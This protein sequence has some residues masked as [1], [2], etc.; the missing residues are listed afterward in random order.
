MASI[1]NPKHLT[2]KLRQS[3]IPE[4]AWHTSERLSDTASSEHLVFD[5]RS[6]DPGKY[7]FPYHFHRNAEEM[8]V[9]LSGRAMLRT[10][11]GFRELEEGDVAFFGI[12][13]EGAHQL[14]NHTEEPFRYLDIRTDQGLDVVEYP[15][16]GKINLL[17]EQEIYLREDRV[18]YYLGE[19]QPA[20]HWKG[21]PGH[22]SAGEPDRSD[23]KE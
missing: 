21:C 18:D 2:Y 9:V 20:E 12:G 10:P 17:P 15:D 22:P 5:I 13:P 4:F 6:L 1:F 14:Y 7:S 19:D 23:L 16:S 3:P 11:E 8:F